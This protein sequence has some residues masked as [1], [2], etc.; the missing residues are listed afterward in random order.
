MTIAPLVEISMDEVMSTF[1]TNTFGALR[2]IQAVS[3][4]MMERKQGLIIN[5]SSIVAR[6]S[7]FPSA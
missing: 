5:V 7:V 4:H 2:M 6:M 3:P 1:N